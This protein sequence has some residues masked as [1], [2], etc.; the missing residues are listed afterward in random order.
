[1]IERRQCTNPG[2]H[3]L[4]SVLPDKLAP[5]K[6]Y[7]TELIEDVVDEIIVPEDPVNEDLPCDTTMRRWKHW[8]MANQLR[9]EGYCRS[10]S[11]RFLN[12]G[13]KAFDHNISLL[14]NIRKT[15]GQWLA[16]VLRMIYNTGGFLVPG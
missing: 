8:F 7:V 14:E 13:E 6:H 4:H 11:R 10:I 2:C 15:E 1:M 12:G 9:V 5:Y 16:V 3:H